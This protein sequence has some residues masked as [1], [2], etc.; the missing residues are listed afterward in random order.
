MEAVQGGTAR[1]DWS[2][3]VPGVL[4][5]FATALVLTKFGTTAL[6]VVRYS[7][8]LAFCVTLPGMLVWRV[9]R[10]NVDGFAADLTFG[11]GLG[12]VGSI[13]T[14]LPARALGVPLA[15]LAVPVAVI[16]AFLVLPSL[17]IHWRSWGPVLPRWWSWGVGVA[18]LLGLAVVTRF[19]LVMEPMKFPDASYQYVDMPFH[20]ALAGELRHH[21]PAQIPYVTDEPLYYHWFV[22]AQAAASSWHTGI[23][24]DQLLRR[25]LPVTITLLTVLAVAV[26]ATRLARVAWAGPVAGGLLLLVTTFDAYGWNGTGSVLEMGFSSGVLIYSPTQAFGMFLAIPV[27]WLVIALLRGDGARAGTW[28]LLVVGLVGVSGA[29][30]TFVPMVTAGLLAV[31][32]VRLL[33]TRRFDR[34]AACLAASTVVI[35]VFAQ[36][37]LFGGTTAGTSVR[38]LRTFVDLAPRYGLTAKPGE[39]FAVLMTALV[40]W[41]LVAAGMAGLARGRKW[42][43]RDAIFLVGFV[44]SGLAAAA[45]ASQHGLSQVYFLR[46]LFP[47]AIAGSVWG[48]SLLLAGRS[49]RVM[50]PWLVIAFLAGLL[51]GWRV[52]VATPDKPGPGGGGTVVWQVTWPWLV[53]V[54]SALMLVF[55]SRLTPPRWRLRGLGGAVAVML[56]FGASS[57]NVPTRV[58]D[59]AKVT[60]CTAGPE[61]PDCYN[62]LQRVPRDGPA[63]ARFI[64]DRSAPSDVLA[65]NSHCTPTS[66]PKLC[67]SRNFWLAAYAER[68]VLLAGWAYTP[69]ANARASSAYE[70]IFGAYWNPGLRKANDAAFRTNPS[71]ADLRLLRERYGVR[72]LVFDTTLGEA[73]PVIRKLLPRRF[74]QG[75]LEVYELVE[76]RDGMPATPSKHVER[77]GRVP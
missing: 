1:V 77:D 42:R 68:R 28:I 47:V 69:T 40:S 23:E 21:F 30:A 55:L 48:L 12:L 24:L 70:A 14:Y 3:F 18:C 33:L 29:K 58:A 13:L 51:I 7:A 54:G 17:A 56:L 73:S 67:D 49:F 36:A 75:S 50:A 53:V 37:V 57:L 5:W 38:V 66:P 76:I 32:V 20:L 11:T 62:P 44:V 72:W 16:I 34:L 64:R 8:Y 52:T 9:L 71:R 45:V 39:V 6:D 35:L 25:L 26:L 65:T 60:L 15:G 4:V 19:A 43:E 63:A 59:L 2:R 61:R 22:H 31:V 27:V 10:G 41:G 74:K 46:G